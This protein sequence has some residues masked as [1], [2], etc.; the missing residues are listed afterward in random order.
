MEIV[1]VMPYFRAL[2]PSQRSRGIYTR[3]LAPFTG[4]VTRLLELASCLHNVC[5]RATARAK[6]A[7]TFWSYPE[8]VAKAR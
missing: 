7:R 3:S 4:A 1:E 5:M 6:S 2:L 8:Q